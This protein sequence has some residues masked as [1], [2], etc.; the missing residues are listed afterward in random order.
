M[1]NEDAGTLWYQTSLDVFLNRWFANYEDAR[2]SLER[3]GGYLLPYRRQFFVCEADVISV[4]G[5][6]PN[7]PDWETI[8]HDAAQPSDESAY[9]RLRQK[10]ENV[11]KEISNNSNEP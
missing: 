3:D 10:R 7:D 4:L 2:A 1:S 9:E 8:A 6:D 11:L 5:L